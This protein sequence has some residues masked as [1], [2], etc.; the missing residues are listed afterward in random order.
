MSPTAHHVE[1]KPK[2]SCYVLGQTKAHVI[3]PCLCKYISCELG[4]IDKTLLVYKESCL[5]QNGLPT[6]YY[7][8]LL[9]QI[10]FL[11]WKKILRRG[12]SITIVT[13]E[14]HKLLIALVRTNNWA[15]VDFKACTQQNDDEQFEKKGTNLVAIF[16]SFWP[17]FT[18]V[19]S[20]V[21]QVSEKSLAGD[22]TPRLFSYACRTLWRQAQYSCRRPSTLA[23]LTVS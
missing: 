15:R 18:S 13:E 16:F 2:Q 9:F 8:S 20:V 14:D 17:K 21:E 22:L 11:D 5:K 10:I 4:R 19:R 3:L 1:Y 7:S 12:D 23:Y 6:S